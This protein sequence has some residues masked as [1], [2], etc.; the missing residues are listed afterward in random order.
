VRRTLRVPATA[1]VLALACRPG[2]RHTEPPP[3]DLARLLEGTVTAV[4]WSIIEGPAGY[5]RDTLYEYLDGGA[6]RYISHGFRRLVSARAARSG[7]SRFEVTVDVFDMGSPLGAFA[8]FRSIVPADA[9]R[10]PLG[11]EGYAA[12]NVVAAWD[13]RVYVHAEVDRGS[14][15]AVG[16]TERAVAKICAGV[17]GDG[18]FPSVL[19]PLPREGLVPRSERYDARDLLGHDFL[20]GGVRASYVID[21]QSG[22]VFFSDL[23]SSSAAAGALAR[24]RAHHARFGTVVGEV[25]GLGNAG[26]RFEGAGLG[27]GVIVQV[28]RHIAGAHGALNID[29][30]NRLLR[31]LCSALDS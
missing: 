2:S 30:A 5:D 11:T 27:T 29:D 12:G 23:G 22:E 4:G 26:F 14:A 3:P 13:G 6:E 15:E 7:T 19:A 10:R 16:E 25:T 24:L 28:G 1:L 20:P 8:I 9:P 18:S 21:G 17:A 31:R